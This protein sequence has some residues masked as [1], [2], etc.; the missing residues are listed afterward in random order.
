MIAMFD[1]L[2]QYLQIK[3]GST[4]AEVGASIGYDNGAMAVFLDS[5]TFYLQDIDESCLNEKNLQKVLKH[6]SKFK[7]Y[8]LEHTNQFHITIGTTFKS[9][10]PTNAIDI[11]YSNATYH[12]LD[13]PDSIMADLHRSLRIN[14][15]ISIRDDFNTDEEIKYCADKKCGNPIA[16]LDDFM[17]TMDRTGFVLIDSTNQFGSTIYNFRKNH[18]RP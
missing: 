9:N 4:F 1:T 10:L 2:N 11:I 12:A 8:P 18:S 5:V 6:Y 16:H 14:G 13:E 15:T 17:S 3:P 7:Y